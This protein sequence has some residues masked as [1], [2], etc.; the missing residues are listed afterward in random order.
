MGVPVGPERATELLPQVYSRPGQLREEYNVDAV[1]QLATIPADVIA[2]QRPPVPQQL[3]PPRTGYRNEQLTITDVLSTDRM[4]PQF[5][6]W[7]SGGRGMP[8]PRQPD[9]LA[10]EG[11]LRNALPVSGVSGGSMG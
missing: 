10:M 7:Q 6:S 11:G 8:A 3:F 2:T 4:A 9:E 1:L 5:R